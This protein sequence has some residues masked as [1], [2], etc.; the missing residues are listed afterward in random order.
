[1]RIS[2]VLVL[3]SLTAACARHPAPVP[4]PPA[5]PAEPPSPSPAV[6]II[7][8]PPTYCV[9][10][11][12]RLEMV[13]LEVSSRGDSAY[14]G[15]PIAQAFPLDSTYAANAPWLRGLEPLALLGDHYVMYGL[16]RILGTTDVVPITTFRGVTVFAERGVDP[17]RPEVIY[18]PTRPGCVFQPYQRHGS[19]E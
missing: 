4:T 13:E 9:L 6:G 15:T 12:G 18:I 16:P 2:S 3:L 17:T 10:V 1:M 19:K 5:A 11:N 7:G 14:R 8:D